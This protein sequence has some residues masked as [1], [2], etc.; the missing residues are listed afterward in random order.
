MP[1]MG[2]S[3]RAGV[4]AGEVE[5]PSVYA[6]AERPPPAGV[7]LLAA[8][9]RRRSAASRRGAARAPAGGAPARA[10]ADARAAR[11]LADGRAGARAA[12]PLV[13]RPRRVRARAQQRERRMEEVVAGGG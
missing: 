12:G 4:D 8:A 2:D 1:G 3:G 10:A 9:A 11:A 6:I 5:P 13:A 7:V